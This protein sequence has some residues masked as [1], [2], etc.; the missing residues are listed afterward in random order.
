V[1][2]SR[3]DVEIETNETCRE[4]SDGW[5][6]LLITKTPATALATTPANV[7]AV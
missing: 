2:G 6:K 4:R 1:Q 7:D 5:K 3:L